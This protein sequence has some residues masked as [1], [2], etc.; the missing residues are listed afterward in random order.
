MA[1]K[2][3]KGVAMQTLGIDIDDSQK[4]S[5]H[6]EVIA[7]CNVCENLATHH[8]KICYRNLCKFCIIDHYKNTAFT[9]DHDM[10]PI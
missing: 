4:K 3:S 6:E 7:F 8:C 5:A 2:P 1:P 9:K 10:E